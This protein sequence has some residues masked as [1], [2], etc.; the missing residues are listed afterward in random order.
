MNK[1]VDE[2][3]REIARSSRKTPML[4]DNIAQQRKVLDQA[5]RDKQDNDLYIADTYAVLHALGHARL[6]ENNEWVI[7]E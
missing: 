5:I 7:A 3:K 2:L 4:E 6:E 1:A